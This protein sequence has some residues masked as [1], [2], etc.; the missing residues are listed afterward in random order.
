VITKQLHYIGWPDH[1]VPTGESINDF[2]T[3][4]DAFID[5]IITSE[6]N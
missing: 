1:G 5:M 6:A 3:M 2:S 4:L